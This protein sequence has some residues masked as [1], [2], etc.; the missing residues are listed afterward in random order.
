MQEALNSVNL[1]PN[2]GGDY[3]EQEPVTT[4][5]EHRT[6]EIGTGTERS[7]KVL[8]RMWDDE[9]FF[10]RQETDHVKGHS[11]RF[12]SL[13]AGSADVMAQKKGKGA[14]QHR[15]DPLNFCTMSTYH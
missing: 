10:T 8:N 3:F 5:K 15:L 7:S 2:D 9:K 12:H 13:D 6:E 1:E 14:H 4:E 11:R